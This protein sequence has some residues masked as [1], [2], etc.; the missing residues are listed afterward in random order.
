MGNLP[1]VLRRFPDVRHFGLHRGRGILLGISSVLQSNINSASAADLAGAHRKTIVT[2]IVTY[3]AMITTYVRA[4]DSPVQVVSL[5][6][7][8]LEHAEQLD[9]LADETGRQ[10]AVDPKL[11]TLLQGEGHALRTNTNHH[12]APLSYQTQREPGLGIGK[13]LTIQYV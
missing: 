8:V 9:I 12:E 11:E 1:L 13:D 3:C 2:I 5:H 7:V 4:S 10:Q 6:V